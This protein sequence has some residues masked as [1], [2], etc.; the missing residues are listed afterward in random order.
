MRLRESMPGAIVA[1]LPRLVRIHGEVRWRGQ[2]AIAVAVAVVLYWVTA[3]YL[4][5]PVEPLP[6]LLV[7][8]GTAVL[9]AIAALLSTRRRVPEALAATR[10]P[11]P[12]LYETRADARDRRS[13]LVLLVL[14]AVAALLVVDRVVDGGGAIAGLVVGL[15]AVLGA[16][17]LYEAGRWRASERER[18]TRLYILIPARAMA[19]RYGRVEVYEA[20]GE[21]GRNGAV[22]GEASDLELWR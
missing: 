17:D 21:G 22:A 6:A 3:W 9:T 5:A 13:K 11:P 14:F 10:R 12:A 16:V 19:G 7:L 18:G 15:F 4:D 1:D 8:A 20:P 2:A